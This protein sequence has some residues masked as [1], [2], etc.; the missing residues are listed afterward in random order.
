MGRNGTKVV[1]L[2]DRSHHINIRRHTVRHTDVMT[3]EYEQKRLAGCG[4]RGDTDC[5]PQRTIRAIGSSV[6]QAEYGDT[7][8]PAIG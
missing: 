1:F 2:T 7:A 5:H 3:K 6:W 8:D 4:I